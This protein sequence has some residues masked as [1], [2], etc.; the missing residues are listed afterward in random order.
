M[1]QSMNLARLTFDNIFI[2]KMK[3]I[4]IS[5]L[6]LLFVASLIFLLKSNFNNHL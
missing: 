2:G 5:L 3:I 6:L 1:V 4:Y